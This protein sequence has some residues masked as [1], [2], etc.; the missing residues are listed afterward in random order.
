LKGD[1]IP[2]CTPATTLMSAAPDGGLGTGSSDRPASRPPGARSSFASEAANLLGPNGD[3]NGV[4]D[5]F[6]KDR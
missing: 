5:V 3:T 6:A 1:P 2:G 4:V